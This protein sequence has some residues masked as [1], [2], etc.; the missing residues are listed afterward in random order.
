MADQVSPL[1]GL[2]PGLAAKVQSLSVTTQPKAEPTKST[3]TTES[4]SQAP[5][6]LKIAEAQSGSVPQ[7]TLDAAAKAVKDYVQQS[8]TDLKFFVDKDTGTYCIK[9]VD[10]ENHETIRQIPA[11]EVLEMSKRLRALSDGKDA[12][13]V[14]MD[15]QG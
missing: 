11:E 7:E 12:S 14:L 6:E 4:K 13:G 2:S 1:G 5:A 8:S 9:I 15:A 3:K 10:P